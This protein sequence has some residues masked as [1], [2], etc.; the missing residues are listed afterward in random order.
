MATTTPDFSA[1]WK[2]LNPQQRDKALSR[3]TPAQKQKLAGSL[4]FKGAPSEPKPQVSISANPPSQHPVQDWLKNAETDLREGGNRTGVGRVLGKM[5]GNEGKYTGLESGTSKSAANFMGSV[6]LGAV[7]TARGVASMGEHPVKGAVDAVKGVAHMAE[8]PGMVMGAPAAEGVPA[9]IGKVLEKLPTATRGASRLN[10][11]EE[12]AG[13]LPVSLTRTEEHLM[14]ASSMADNGATLPTPIKKLLKRYEKG[15]SLDYSDAREFYSNLSRLTAKDS[16]SLSPS[17]KRQLGLIVQALRDDI[18][19]T[20][21]QVDKAAQ[22]YGGLKDYARAK[23][24][25][26]I[27]NILR[28]AATSKAVKYGLGGAA[29]YGVAKAIGKEF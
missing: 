21:A 10:E 12:A 29:A 9:A 27:G 11:V 4:G 5:Q 20:A 22:Y 26:R 16:M 13:H 1:Q 18:G 23:K 28:E 8:M 17:M 19:T 6:P 24:A 3:M 25:A 2:A 7:E 14:K 15:E